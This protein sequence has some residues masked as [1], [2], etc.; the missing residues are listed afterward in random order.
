MLKKCRLHQYAHQ[1]PHLHL[2]TQTLS[3][4]ITSTAWLFSFPSNKTTCAT[5]AQNKCSPTQATKHQTSP[6]KKG[7]CL[8]LKRKHN[9]PSERKALFKKPEFFSIRRKWRGEHICLLLPQLFPFFIMVS[10]VGVSVWG[11]A[12]TSR[13]GMFVTRTTR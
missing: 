6:L 8:V 5:P 11:D 2:T 1:T 12:L 9:L 7:L 3:L 10:A 13:G 4:N